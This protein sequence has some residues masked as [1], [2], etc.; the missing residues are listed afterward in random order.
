M[1]LLVV[2]PHP[3][4]LGRQ[5]VEKLQDRRIPV[6][7]RQHVGGPDVGDDHVLIGLLEEL[8]GLEDRLPGLLLR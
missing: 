5:P 2:S 4:Q 7:V 3:L 1:A 6:E 8:T